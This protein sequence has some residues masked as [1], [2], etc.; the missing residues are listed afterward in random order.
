M[1]FDLSRFF[2]DAVKLTESSLSASLLK[3]GS[4]STVGMFKVENNKL[5]IEDV[6]YSSLHLC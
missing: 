2:H 1:D 4:C 6:N 3:T 5:G